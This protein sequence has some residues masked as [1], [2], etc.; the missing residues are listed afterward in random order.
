MSENFSHNMEYRHL[1]KRSENR[2]VLAD[3]LLE[4]KD[5]QKEKKQI[6]INDGEVKGDV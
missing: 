6:Y 5:E 2:R 1:F 4:H 3:T